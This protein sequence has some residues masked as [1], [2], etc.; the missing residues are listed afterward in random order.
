MNELEGGYNLG[1]RDSKFVSFSA[2]RFFL[3]EG[4]GFQSKN[5]RDTFDPANALINSSQFS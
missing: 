4:M 1:R 3:G 2:S 5:K